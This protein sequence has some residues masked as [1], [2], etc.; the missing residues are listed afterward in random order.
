MP[1]QSIWQVLNAD[2]SDSILH[3][4]MRLCIGLDERYM[5]SVIRAV[6]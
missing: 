1:A 2:G 5:K 6:E 3:D 4:R